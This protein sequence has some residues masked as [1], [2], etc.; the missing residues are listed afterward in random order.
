[1]SGYRK[2]GSTRTWSAIHAVSYMILLTESCFSYVIF[3][4]VSS[5]NESPVW[6]LL[7]RAAIR[8]VLQAPPSW[9]TLGLGLEDYTA[10]SEPADVPSSYQGGTLYRILTRGRL[11]PTID[12]EQL[13]IELLKLLAAS[14]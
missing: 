7:T 11:L 8:L 14:L 2:V 4:T 3:F 10:I 13:S 12:L 6:A 9:G 1:M 5:Q